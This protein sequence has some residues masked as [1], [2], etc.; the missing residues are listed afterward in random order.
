ML[1]QLEKRERASAL[2]QHCQCVTLDETRLEEALGSELRSLL[3]RSATHA[4]LFAQA[5]VFLP[6]ADGE[7]M[8][9]I[10]RAIEAAASTAPYRTTAL[11]R[12]TPLAQRD[13]GPRGAFM[14]YD[15]H[16]TAD[17]PRL[18]EINTNAGGAF[19][20]AILAH[21]QRACCTEVERGLARRA[22]EAFASDVVGMFKAEWQSQRGDAAL[23]RIAIVDTDPAGQYLLPEFVLA[24]ALLRRAGYAVDIFD[25]RELTFDGHSLLG[26]GEPIDLV[27]NRLVDFDFSEFDHTELRRAYETGSV[28]VTPN[29]HNH[30]LLA[31]KRNLIT[32]SDQSIGLLP[33]DVASRIPSAIALTKDNADALWAKRSQFFFKPADGHGGKAVY[34]GDKLTRGVWPS[35]LEREYIAQKL[36]AP[37]E[38][39]VRVGDEVVPRKVDVRLYTYGGRPLLTA[40]RLYQGQTTNFRTPGGGFAPVFFV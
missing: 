1:D 21:A 35:L 33:S 32:L 17:G 6:E 2:N 9:D 34:R 25:P 5:P 28:V 20:N 11:G 15:F 12:A 39:S 10:V 31:D 23:R 8:Q 38:R 40:A 36:I 26:A 7:A 13:F 3:D 18:I 24:R 27:Y 16:L 30:A 4:H 14:G 19:L 22:L 29:P 37:S